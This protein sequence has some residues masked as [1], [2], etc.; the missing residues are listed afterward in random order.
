MPQLPQV[1]VAEPY[2]P[3]DLAAVLNKNMI[4]ACGEGWW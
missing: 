4:V 2:L 3:L 1:I